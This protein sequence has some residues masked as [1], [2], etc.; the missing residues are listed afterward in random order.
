MKM[1]ECCLKFH[2]KLLLRFQLTI[3]QHWLRY[4]LGATQAT[5][6]YLNQWWLVYWCIYASLG[7]AELN[8]EYEYDY[9]MC[10]LYHSYIP[11]TGLVPYTEAAVVY[12]HVCCSSIVTSLMGCYKGHNPS[13][14]RLVLCLFSMNLSS[15][16][17]CIMSS[18]G[19]MIFVMCRLSVWWYCNFSP[20]H[21]NCLIAVRSNF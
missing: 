17:L 8:Y 19:N 10:S 13:A 2:W 12:V 3:F 18:A 4:W 1:Y 16:L 9:S 14:C 15:I 11:I 6:H 21:S 5:S 20:R 7:F